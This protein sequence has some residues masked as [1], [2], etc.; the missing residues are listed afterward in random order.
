MNLWDFF[1]KNIQ[2]KGSASGVTAIFLLILAIWTFIWK[3]LSLWK[4]ARNGQKI[5][6]ILLLLIST[7]GILDIVYLKFFQKKVDKVTPQATSK[8][9]KRV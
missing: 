6:F 8:K 1:Y 7:V 9:E 2:V 4:S 3:G 5:W